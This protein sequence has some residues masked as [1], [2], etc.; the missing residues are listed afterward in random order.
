M[1]IKQGKI[2][3]KEKDTG[4]GEEDSAM[5]GPADFGGVF[6]AH[7][8]Q[9]AAALAS[10]WSWILCPSFTLAKQAPPVIN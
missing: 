7:I 9:P 3:E 10:P 8:W 1:P 6:K 5:G 4:E 2:D